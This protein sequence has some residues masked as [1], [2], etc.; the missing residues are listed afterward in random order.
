MKLCLVAQQG[1]HLQQLLRLQRAWAG[2]EH[3][4]VL[5]A[6][7]VPPTREIQSRVYFL[8]SSDRKTP[9][10]ILLNFFPAWRILRKEKPDVILSTGA[11]LA[12][13]F[14]F[15][16]RVL[17]IP[18]IWVDSQANTR[19]LSMTGGFLRPHVTR[20]YTQWEELA[21]DGVRYRGRV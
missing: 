17:G 3:F 18:C 10:R 19:K 13:P 15:W 16:G 1:G 20:C 2:I 5:T 14:V 21:Q 8:R 11:A 12:I 7:Q 6:H 4:H 9:W